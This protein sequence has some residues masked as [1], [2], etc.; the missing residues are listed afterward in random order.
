MFVT[1]KT[2]KD[3]TLRGCKGT[4]S[5]INLISGLKTYSLHSA[6]QD[7]RFSPV[8]ASEL[9]SLTC[10]ISLLTD[11]DNCSSYDDWTIGTHGISIKFEDGGHHYSGIYL[12]EVMTEYGTP[13]QN[14][15]LSHMFRI[16]SRR[17]NLQS[18]QKKRP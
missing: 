10:S 15:E 14:N 6:L 17:G 8:K 5:P 18:H 1:W 3:Q 2:T 13:K 16:H 9:D 4:T 7:G 11:Y 12:P